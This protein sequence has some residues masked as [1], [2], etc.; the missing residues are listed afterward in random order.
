MDYVCPS[1][2]TPMRIPAKTVLSLLA[3][4]RSVVVRDATY[5][6]VNSAMPYTEAV[7]LAIR[8]EVEGITTPSGKIRYLRLLPASERVPVFAEAAHVDPKSRSTAV[9][10][11]NM[12]VYRQQVESTEMDEY[13][14][15]T[16]IIIG[17]VYA[18]CLLRASGI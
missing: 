16:R 11:T 18:H 14:T 10:Q 8:G 1:V 3:P 2:S 12:G 17:H 5:G 9:A 15:P 13:G 7:A 6:C 4:D